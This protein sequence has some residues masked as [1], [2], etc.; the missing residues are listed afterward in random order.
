MPPV[1]NLVTSSQQPIKVSGR[2][3]D[4]MNKEPSMSGQT[5]VGLIIPP[6]DIRT[7]VDK[8]ALFVARNGVEFENKIREREA[9]NIR[10]NFL[11]PVDPYHAYYKNKV[12]EFETGVASAELL[13]KIKIPDAIREHIK[14]AEFVPKNPPKPFEFCADPSTI[15]A[16]DLD[17]I[18]LTALF[19]ARNGRQFLTQLMNREVRNFQFDFLKPQHSNFQYFTKLVEQYTKV[20]IPPKNVYDE[21]RNSASHQKIL[22]DVRYRVG[23][24]KFQRA[25]KDREDAEVEQERMAYNQIDWHDFVVVQ[26][27]DFQPSETLN[28]PSLC[29]PRDVGARI[30]LQQRTEAAKAA[31]ES[32]AMDMDESESDEE[33]EKKKQKSRQDFD[34]IQQQVG[35]MDIA[36][37]QHA[38]STVTQPT[39][40]A[41]IAGNVVI[42]DY[43]PKKA[44]SGIAKGH[45]KFIIS[46]L[47]NER[48]P[49]DKLHEHVRYNT[50]DPQFKEQRD[51]EHMERQDEDPITASGTEISRNIAK[52]AERRT[53][54]FGIGEKGV[55]QT[56]IGKKKLG[57]EE[58]QLPR[59]DPKTI[60]DGQQATIDATTRAAQQA[61]SLEQQ[62]TEIQRQHGYLPNP[63][64]D[65][66]AP[67]TPSTTS[68]A[69]TAS[70]ASMPPP[71]TAVPTPIPPR[72][73][74]IQ[75]PI[76]SNVAKIIPGGPPQQQQPMR[77]PR[78]PLPGM[79]P[80]PHMLPMGMQIPGLPPHMA[81]A[82]HQQGGHFMPPPPPP[83]ESGASAAK[84]FRVDDA[85]EPEELWLQK[86]SGQ[87]TVKLST[88]Q[89]DEWNL[90]GQTFTIQLEITSTVSA[91]KSL[92]QEQTTVP[93]SK[94][95]LVYQNTFLK[96]NFTLA[97]YNFVNEANVQLLLKER[98][99]KKK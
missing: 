97:Y 61:V 71:T 91:L 68:A 49:A 8:T 23:W 16:F 92:I 54:I 60:W 22:D 45:E 77:M 66:F 83:D 10:F 69:T 9:S 25:V 94:A 36:E 4:S 28:L 12:K 73:P 56:I 72:P 40:A 79:P 89:T 21:L 38:G 24:E 84:K 75:P 15:N 81:M 78:M 82:H 31:A 32:V 96:D 17:L 80:P 19:V 76:I 63:A 42:R 95:K 67:N 29:T 52:L 50:V 2:E 88:P 64:A 98:G 87:I 18:Q 53:D 59:S 11:T 74:H 34:D 86:V 44:R 1:E 5:I 51:R 20:I 48:I 55:E 65:R 99:G 14:K 7:I 58:R 39:P 27:V 46:P 90:K 37:K 70:A 35:G 13:S 3:E 41:P 30:L 62:I 43:D 93:A 47:T 33:E 6:P 85:L 26:T 57:E